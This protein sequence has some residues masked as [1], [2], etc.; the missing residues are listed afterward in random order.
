MAD[1]T[2]EKIDSIQSQPQP[3]STE[4]TATITASTRS[5]QSPVESSFSA[6]MNFER[7]DDDDRDDFGL[8]ALC[9]SDDK[10]ADIFISKYDYLDSCISNEIFDENLCSTL[11]LLL[12]FILENGSTLDN[13]FDHRDQMDMFFT[14][15]RNILRNHLKF[16]PD[17]INLLILRLIEIRASKW[18]INPNIEEYYMSKLGRTVVCPM[19]AGKSNA[20][21][22]NSTGISGSNQRSQERNSVRM[23]KSFGDLHHNPIT[24]E[25]TFRNSKLLKSNSKGALKDEVLIKNSDSGK[26]MGIKGRRVHMIEEMSD[27]IISFQRVSPNAKDRLVQIT[28]FNRENIERA[29]NLIDVTIRQNIS[30][31][32]FENDSNICDATIFENDFLNQAVMNKINHSNAHNNKHNNNSNDNSSLKTLTNFDK[33]DRLMHLEHHQHHLQQQQQRKKKSISMI[34]FDENRRERTD[35][36]KNEFAFSLPFEDDYIMIN[37][38]N[39]NVGKKIQEFLRQH[40]FLDSL[41]ADYLASEES[42][43]LTM[44]PKRSHLDRSSTSI[45]YDRE[46]LL[47]LR[48]LD[49]YNLD[50]INEVKQKQPSLLRK[51]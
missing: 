11:V 41:R 27:T 45:V 13:D 42:S 24:L 28:G 33:T 10:L 3:P 36:Q 46:F 29:K 32:P 35:E 30:P 21:R 12:K 5:N 2:F 39:R 20:S 50:I 9:I 44:G 48:D 14:L 34:I 25:E 49:D 47:S 17:S 43:C 23:S 1:E 15:F 38:S 26:V 22:T 19:N 6:M 16:L 37:V 7:S 31:I 40:K 4:T 51:I 8:D 18:K